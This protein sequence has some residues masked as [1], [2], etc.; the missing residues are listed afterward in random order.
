MAFPEPITD[1]NGSLVIARIQS[2][3]YDAVLFVGWRLD[4]AG[5]A[6]LNS[7][8]ASTIQAT[9]VTAQHFV[10]APGNLSL[11]LK[12]TTGGTVSGATNASGDVTITHGL[13]TTPTWAYAIPLGSATPDTIA[14]WHVISMTSTQITFRAY[15]TDGVAA[16]AAALASNPVNFVWA[17]GE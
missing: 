2:P 14:K 13:G 17:C 1:G 9:T 7:V 3:N 4:K 12:A 10:K 16:P 15:R 5:Q 11:E 8:T 6:F